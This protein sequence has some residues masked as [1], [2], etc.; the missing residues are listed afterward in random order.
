[1][2][3]QKNVATNPVQ[4]NKY[5]LIEGI[6][7]IPSDEYMGYKTFSSR[8]NDIPQSLN[9]IILTL[10]YSFSKWMMWAIPNLQ[11]I[12]ISVERKVEWKK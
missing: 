5:T 6:H 1:M 11:A 2:Q 7:W 4:K 8:L 10:N 3:I 12:V 9:Q